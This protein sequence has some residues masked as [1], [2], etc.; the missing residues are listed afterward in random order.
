MKKQI[1]YCSTADLKRIR[2]I[3]L[4]SKDSVAEKINYSLR[5]LERI[6]KENATRDKETAQ[7]L[8]DLYELEFKEHFFKS[9]IKTFNT[10]SRLFSEE[11]DEPKN[12]V[13]ENE[14]YYFMFIRRLKFGNAFVASKLR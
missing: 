1:R 14:V 2:E 7:I 11:G 9:D 3:L 6:E 4:Y 13:L 8:C 5:T 12:V 10:M